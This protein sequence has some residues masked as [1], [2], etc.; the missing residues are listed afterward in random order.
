MKTV[1]R[2]WWITRPERSPDNI[3]FALIALDKATN[4][5]SNVQWNH[6]TQFKYEDWL[7]N[8]G[9]KRPGR[10]RNG[11][12]GR[13]WAAMLK[14]YDYVYKTKNRIMK[15]NEVAKEIIN[16]NNVYQNIQK[17]ILILQIPNP[18]FLSKDF[19]RG[20]KFSNDFQIQPVRFLLK[21][22]NNK[23]LNYKI[24]EKEIIYFAMTC[25]KNSDLNKAITNICKFRNM[26]SDQKSSWE[27]KIAK[28]FDHRA[29]KDSPQRTFEQNMKDTANTFMIL[30][31]YT[32]LTHR[33][34]SKHPSVLYSDDQYAITNNNKLKKLDYRYPFDTT[35]FNDITASIF[36]EGLPVGKYKANY[37]PGVAT[38][39]LHSKDERMAWSFAMKH[40]ELN[41]ASRQHIATMIANST[42]LPPFKTNHFANLIKKYEQTSSFS[43]S[44]QNQYLHEKDTVTHNKNR[45]FELDTEYVLRHMGL[46]VEDHPEPVSSENNSNENEDAVITVHN[47]YLILVDAKNYHNKSDNSRFPLSAELRNTMVNSYIKGYIGYKNKKPKYF[48]YVVAKNASGLDN[49]KHI[50]H[51]SDHILGNKCTG[52]IISAECLMQLASYEDQHKTNKTTNEH[53]LIKLCSTNKLFTTF[54]KIK[55]CLR[56]ND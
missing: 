3:K 34:K 5:F 26:A 49:M 13:T 45:Q 4:H 23:Q 10:D 40:P 33:T 8:E 48:L 47:K 2:T 36:R 16:G 22:A 32:G 20:K 1:R 28:T 29:R 55:D 51:D 6:H 12:G 43:K 14:T 25:H 11:S 46:N 31:E 41:N 27:A 50:T 30:A 15:P 38:A 52:A 42:G 21:L 54:G 24:S 56:L 17:Q 35:C 44:F 53:Y 18:Y 9:V 7:G 39:N 19:T 37:R